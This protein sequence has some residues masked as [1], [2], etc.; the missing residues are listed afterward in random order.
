MHQNSNAVAWAM[1]RMPYATTYKRIMQK[2]GEPVVLSSFDELAEHSG[3][4]MAPFA[5]SDDCP[6]YVIKP[7]VTE[8]HSVQIRNI[9]GARHSDSAEAEEEM[10]SA[11]IQQRCKERGRYSETFSMFH[12]ALQDG[13]FKKIVLARYSDDMI[14]EDTE[15]EDLFHY[16]CE[17]YPR[18]FIAMVSV[19][20]CGTWLVAS[21]EVL[22]EGSG[23][24]W[25]TVALAGTMNLENN[26]I[27]SLADGK[28]ESYS[29]ILWSTKNIQEQHYVAAYINDCLKNIA[30]DIEETGPYTVRAGHLVH[31]KSDFTF[32]I[33]NNK[34][35]ANL[36]KRLHPTPAVCGLPKDK[37]FE[38]IIENEGFS[39]KYYSGFMG[40]VNM[41]GETHLFVSLRCM[42]IAAGYCRLYAGGGLLTSSEEE[43]EWNETEAKLETMRRCIAIRKI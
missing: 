8:E 23:A 4:C 20:K 42:N 15:Y 7:D 12:S 35:I 14:P 30:T 21:P 39:R 22:L 1:Y 38:Y 5:L 3:F 41:S 33:D 17:L 18:L 31:L 25:H 36:L 9:N 40:P 16:A 24:R 2:N 37:A 19:D 6:I 13:C 28:D 29:N 10:K 27:K 43:S 26:D 32:T 34:S 11:T